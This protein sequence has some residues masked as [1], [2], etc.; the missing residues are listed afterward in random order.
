MKKNRLNN[1][2]VSK[3]YPAVGIPL[4]LLLFPNTVYAGANIDVATVLSNLRQIINPI[5][6]LVLTIS[7]LGGVY[8]FFRGLGMLKQFGM[9]LTQMSRPGEFAGPMVYI[10]VGAF[11]IYLPT[12]T[13][14]VTTTIFGE[15][16]GSIFSGDTADVGLVGRASEELV[17]YLP[18]SVV[19]Q[20]ADIT[21]TIVYFIQMIGFIAFVRGWFIISKAGNPGVQPGSI[22]KGIIHIVGGILAVNFIPFMRA[23]GNTIFGT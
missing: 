16:G 13:D 23:I 5:I 18:G 15:A 7:F 11:L 9:P 10:V 2:E 12:S 19:E 4:F 21:D 1:K 17:G 14:V 20:W 8:M 22:S 3:L 6:V